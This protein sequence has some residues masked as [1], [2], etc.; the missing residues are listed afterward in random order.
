M[1]NQEVTAIET[2]KTATIFQYYADDFKNQNPEAALDWV[3]IQY[4][5]LIE[6]CSQ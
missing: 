5:Q 4:D 3:R 6:E 1:P 2:S